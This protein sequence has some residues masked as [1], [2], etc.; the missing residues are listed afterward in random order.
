[1]N[2]Q[3]THK[4]CLNCTNKIIL[5]LVLIFVLAIVKQAQVYNTKVHTEQ[6]K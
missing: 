4:E 1:M 5:F 3:Q 2:S 6:R